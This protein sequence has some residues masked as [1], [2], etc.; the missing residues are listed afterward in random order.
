MVLLS[1]TGS[2]IHYFIVYIYSV[3]IG[4]WSLFCR[5]HASN[6][7]AAGLSSRVNATLQSGPFPCKV[8]EFE[9]SCYVI[10]SREWEFRKI[11]QANVKVHCFAYHLAKD[12]CILRQFLT[13]FC[14]LLGYQRWLLATNQQRLLHPLASVCTS[15]CFC[16]GKKPKK[17]IE[18]ECVSSAGVRNQRLNLYNLCRNTLLVKILLN[19]ALGI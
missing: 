1:T 13:I 16:I 8:E 12:G 18:M 15:F 3:Q 2:S 17:V 11:F 9:P 5:A 4:I 19:N 14:I 7:W 10:C 6:P